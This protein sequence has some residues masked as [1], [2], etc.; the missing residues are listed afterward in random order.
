MSSH[1]AVL[2]GRQA[3]VSRLELTD[4]LTPRVPKGRAGPGWTAARRRG[5]DTD[6]DLLSEHPA[7]SRDSREPGKGNPR[8]P[9]GAGD[10]GCSLTDPRGARSGRRVG[11]GQPPSRDRSE[12]PS[13]VRWLRGNQGGGLGPQ[14]EPSLIR[15]S[16]DL[17]ASALGVDKSKSNF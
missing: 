9:R 13:S 7:P 14:S 3:S 4:L 17:E 16:S 5:K 6:G 2:W 15:A 10:T 1:S 12:Q 8:A 11:A